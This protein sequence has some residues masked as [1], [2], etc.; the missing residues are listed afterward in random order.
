MF[1]HF[2]HEYVKSVNHD[3]YNKSKVKDFLILIDI[4]QKKTKTK[5]R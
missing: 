3:F 1:T 5:Y 2:F 4:Y